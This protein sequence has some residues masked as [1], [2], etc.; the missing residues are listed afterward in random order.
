MKNENKFI[1]YGILFYFLYTQ[2]YKTISSILISPIL[3]MQWNVI[4]IPIL[5]ILIILLF[6]VWLYKKEKFPKIKLW[7][8]LSVL[9][10]SITVS[11]FNIPDRFYLSGINSDYTIKQQYTITNYILTFKTINTL[12]FIAISYFKYLK[13]QKDEKN[14][15]GSPSCS[16]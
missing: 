13:Y 3:I 11:F 7:F 5:L 6:S 10:L 15:M 14:E 4:F 12:I 2:I 1:Y 16:A 8:V 9:F